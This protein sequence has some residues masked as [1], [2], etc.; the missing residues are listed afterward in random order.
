MFAAF[1][2]RP[3]QPQKRLARLIFEEKLR[4]ALPSLGEVPV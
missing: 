3:F 1:K 2:R 4:A